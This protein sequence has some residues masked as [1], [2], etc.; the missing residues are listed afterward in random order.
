M[1]L[2]GGTLEW[3]GSVLP[4][5]PQNL[6]KQ[7]GS[8]LPSRLMEMLPLFVR[9]FLVPAAFSSRCVS[10]E[11]P[12]P[13]L[14]AAQDTSKLSGLNDNVSEPGLSGAVRQLWG[15]NTRSWPA[16]ALCT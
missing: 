16:R 5:H 14:D 4:C 11:T 12:T 10:A 6:A 9:S 15:W 1:L 3:Q 8:T 7:E 2:A 13:L